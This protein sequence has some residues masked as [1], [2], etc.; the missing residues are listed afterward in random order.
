MNDRT[1]TNVLINIARTVVLTILSFMTFPWVCRYLG[2]AQVGIYTWCNT[3]VMYFLVLAKIGIP[4]LAIRECVKV[5]DD[6]EK[7]SNKVQA[8]FLIQLVTTVLSFGLMCALVFSVKEFRNNNEIIFLLSINFLSGAFS[9]EWLFIALEKQFYMSVRSIIVLALSTLLIIIFVT[10]PSDIY[11]YAFITAGVTLVT[12]I[13]NIIYARKFIS[14]KKTMP[15]NL[16]QYFKLLLVLCS[17]S[18][19]ISF[20]NQTDTFILGFIDEGKKEVASY[21]VGIK[22]IDVIIGVITALSTVFIP[23]AAICYAQE[24]KKYFNRLNEYSVNICLFIVLPAIA[25]MTTLSRPITGLIS[26]NYEFNA[27]L[28]Y[29]NAP[30]VLIILSS[31]MITY[32]ISDIIYGQ[33]LLPMKKERFYLYALLGGT[34]LNIA[35]SIVFGKYVFKNN[36][37]VGVAIGTSVT[38]LLILVFLVIVSW[39][40][41]KKAIFNLNSL[42]IFLVAAAIAVFS[43]FIKDPIYNFL[44]GKG[45]SVVTSMIIELVGIVF[46]DA[47]IYLVA[48]GI[49]KEDLVSSF[50]RK[51]RVENAK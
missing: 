20:Y 15:Y 6:K 49:L 14:L 39:K 30:V 34:L 28:G 2:S 50:L 51:K 31:M 41:I 25:T 13:V 29:T 46:I 32:S 19:I 45:L 8:F 38:D 44:L 47:I 9:F 4:N 10:N 42:K 48:L 26:G 7:L 22:G 37:A 27:E 23:R 43:F 12:S 35:L 17:I 3:F 33:I 36:P 16:K 24:D 18:L 11:I 21:S 40:W 5:K 1:R